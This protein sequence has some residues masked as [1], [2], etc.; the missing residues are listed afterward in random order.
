MKEV[1]ESATSFYLDSEPSCYS[2]LRNEAD[3]KNTK[4]YRN[5]KDQKVM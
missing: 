3:S 2:E 5:N 4:N 1:K